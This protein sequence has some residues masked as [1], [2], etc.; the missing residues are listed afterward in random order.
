MSLLSRDSGGRQA[1]HQTTCGDT[2]GLQW[3]L[4]CNA[5]TDGDGGVDGV[6]GGVDGVD[7]GVDGVDGG[8]NAVLSDDGVVPLVSALALSLPVVRAG[9]EL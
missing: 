7:D 2:I 6:D 3:Y 8:G 9:W 1:G 5:D 4:G